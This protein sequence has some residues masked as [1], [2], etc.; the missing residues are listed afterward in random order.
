VV[1]RDSFE[2]LLLTMVQVRV[3]SINAASKYLLCVVLSAAD[4]WG[5]HLLV[6]S[7]RS[8]GYVFVSS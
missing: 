6:G 7:A 5:A 1:G 3:V 8:G 4:H 2:G